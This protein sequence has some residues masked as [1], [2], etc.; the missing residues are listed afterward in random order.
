MQRPGNSN[1]SEFIIATEIGILHRLKRNYPGKT[2]Y[3]ANER[4]SCAYMKVTTLAKV[5]ESLE[6]MHHRITVPEAIA[7]RAKLAIDRMV[8]VGGATPST[9]PAPGVDPGE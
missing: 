4:A 2:F 1:A 6:Q 3:A 9:P 8:S 7:K 5:A